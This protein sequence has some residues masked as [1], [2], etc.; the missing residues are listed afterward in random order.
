MRFNGIFIYERFRRSD[1]IKPKHPDVDDAMWGR[2]DKIIEEYRA[3]SGAVIPVLRE[4]QNVVGY[5]PMEIMDYISQ[6]LNVPASDVF[7]VASFYS[8]FS[9]APKGRHVIRACLGTACYVKGIKEIIDRISNKYQ[10]K[11]GG[12]SDDRRFTLETVRCLGACGLAPV[13][14]I[15]RDIHG[16]MEAS[17]IIDITEKYQ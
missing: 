4:C 12:T 1:V 8:L 3:R 17:R 9:F 6:G 15:D 16:N 7:G 5:L 11:E 10:V 14:V 2:I 13:M